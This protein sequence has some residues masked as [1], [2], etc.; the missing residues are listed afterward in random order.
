MTDLR[1]LDDARDELWRAFGAVELVPVAH[2]RQRHITFE[3]RGEGTRAIAKLYQGVTVDRVREICGAERRA[4]KAGV[5]VP[6]ELYRSRAM[7]LVVHEFV[8]GEHRADLPSALVSVSATSFVGVVAALGAFDPGWRSG[9]P[10]G[11][12]RHARCALA[13]S[14]DAAVSAM[15]TSCWDRLVGLDRS[16]QYRPCHGD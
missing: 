4:R 9:R 15:I 8:E 11:L 2:P 7:P 10:A 12:P 6:K 1:Q 5:P 13:T 3:V 14:A 16:A